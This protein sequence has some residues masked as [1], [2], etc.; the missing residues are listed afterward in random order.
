MLA[1]DLRI[2]GRCR[3]GGRAAP[4]ARPVGASRRRGLARRA[5][6][7][8][9][10][11]STGD[12]SAPSTARSP[13]PTP[14]SS[15]RDGDRFSATGWRIGA[16]RSRHGCRPRRGARTSEPLRPTARTWR[17]RRVAAGALAVESAARDR[18]QIERELD[19]NDARLNAA[20]DGLARVQAAQREVETEAHALRAHHRRVGGVR[21]RRARAHGRARGDPS[22]AR[23]RRGRPTS[24]R[25]GGACRAGR[26]D[27]RTASGRSAADAPRGAGRRAR[28]AASD[29][30]SAPGR[31]RDPARR[32]TSPSASA[33]PRAAEQLERSSACSTGSRPSWPLHRR[34]STASSPG[35]TRSGGARSRRRGRSLRH[36]TICACGA[37]R[38]SASS[39]RCASAPAV[40][41]STRPR[42]RC[43]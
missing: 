5:A 26:L 10:S 22:G 6:R 30:A 35:C 3:R 16:A 36:S 13:T 28:R 43:A 24:P 17:L 21:Q 14:W 29:A 8:A 37:R 15:P 9:S 11:S 27:E 25:L 19:E 34:R 4:V 7:L 32:P 33:L 20:A 1:A 40:P 12:G 42:S 38:R 18:E 39:R 31:G 23:G 2:G 41:S